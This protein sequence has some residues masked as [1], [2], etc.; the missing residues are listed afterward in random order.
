MLPSALRK[1]R[2]MISF[3][4]YILAASVAVLL[5]LQPDVVSKMVSSA[6]HHLGGCFKENK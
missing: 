4:R 6:T 5:D 3:Y 2:E 1:E